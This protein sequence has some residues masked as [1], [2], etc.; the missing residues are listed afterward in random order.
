[1]SVLKDVNSTNLLG[2]EVIDL[3]MGM[4]VQNWQKMM[5]TI[6]RGRKNQAIMRPEIEKREGGAGDE[7]PQMPLGG[8]NETSGRGRGSRYARYLTAE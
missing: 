5:D 1:M 8:R 3:R 2:K 6:Y 4:Y 7:I